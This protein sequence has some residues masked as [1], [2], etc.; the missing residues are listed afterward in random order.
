M[1]DGSPGTPRGVPSRV[2]TD[3]EARDANARWLRML[4]QE[5]VTPI[6]GNT[7]IRP[8]ANNPDL[9]GAYAE[10]TVRALVERMVSP[11]RVSRGA[12]IAPDHCGEKVKQLDL[13]VWTPHPM[14]ALFE[15]GD[16]ALVP[17]G[18]AIAYMEIKARNY[19]ARVGK[20]ISDKLELASQLITPCSDETK[21]GHLYP[22]ALG[23]VCLYEE[24]RAKDMVLDDLVRPQGERLPQAVTLLR[25]KKGGRSVD[26]DHGGI[27]DLVNFLEV[28]RYRSAMIAQEPSF[29]N[30]SL[31]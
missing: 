17:R 9:I 14:P 22:C 7:D 28:V 12:I 2:A 24:G 18:S 27:H 26:A 11:L 29:T 3:E 4:A 1:A 25:R 8:F 23:V 19:N 21:A 6:Q 15:V 13:I 16:F 5:L 30:R 20:G 10:G 31:L